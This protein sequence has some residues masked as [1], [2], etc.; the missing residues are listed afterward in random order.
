MILGDG[1]QTGGN[2]AT[3]DDLFRRAGVRHPDA[4]A[5]TDPP[6]LEII[7]GGSP[8][9]LTFAQTDR[10]VTA[11]ADALRA[12]GLPSDTPVAL[13][14]AN[15]VESVVALLGVLRAGMIA[16]PMPLLWRQQDIV[17]AL[18][19]IG[20]KAIITQG[21][22]GTVPYAELAMQAAVELFPIRYVCA[23]GSE[24][25]DGVVPLDDVFTQ[26]P[27]D[28][29]PTARAGNPA[30]H[31]AV[32]TFERG[33][34]GHLAVARNHLELIAG[35]L[36]VF[37]ESAM[38]ADA[39]LLSTIPLSSTA[40]L[41]ASLL[42]WLLS[43]GA[44]HLHHAFDATTFAAQAQ[45]LN[46]G[47]RVVP[48]A[49]LG[50]LGETGLL[51]GAETVIALW[52][53]P[54]RLAASPPWRHASTLI[55]VASFGE[56]GVLARQRNAQGAPGAIALGRFANPRDAGGAVTAAE[57]RRS[58][59]GTLALRG[60]MVPRHAFPPGAAHGHEPHLETDDDNFVDTGY[61]CRIDR[62]RQ[63]LTVTGPPGG[64]A[65]IGGYRFRPG[66]LDALVAEAD[67]TLV[68]L[69]DPLLGQ[70]LAGAAADPAALAA[71][72]QARGANPLITGAFR[73]RG[74]SD[75][76]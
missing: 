33:V 48:A 10:A 75:A 32:V 51:E 22:I 73:V 47:V 66:E 13:Q 9:A 43:G 55:D 72:L 69:P 41:S 29:A 16:V 34:D 15:T 67:A 27:A 37:L 25:P 8:R 17:D 56:T 44:L 5:L 31:V 70:R 28:F 63:E 64:M 35:G 23:F 1:D 2:R 18:G 62:T 36:G 74:R 45:A 71:D 3:L 52:R 61:T 46:G 11:M 12:L 76:A 14:F 19:R 26:T 30:A 42:P 57:T 40:G 60:P 7:T 4:L 54:E 49:A 6:N 65:A 59:A 58:K 20:A 39:D 53:S 21:R 24:L 38:A 68:A 50:A